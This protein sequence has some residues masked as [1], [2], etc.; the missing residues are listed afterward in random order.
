MQE[1]KLAGRKNPPP[2]PLSMIIKVKPQPK[3]AKMD[4]ASL[5]EPQDTIKSSNSDTEKPLDGVLTPKGD[6]E[7]SCSEVA[8]PSLVSYTDESEDDDT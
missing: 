1:H 7:E 2:R 4:S 6:A 8:K 3:K 5:E